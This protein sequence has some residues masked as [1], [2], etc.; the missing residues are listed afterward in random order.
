MVET[1]TESSPKSSRQLAMLLS[2]PPRKPTETPE[3]WAS[4]AME[5]L[6]QRAQPQDSMSRPPA[7][8]R[9]RVKSTFQKLPPEVRYKVGS[10]ELRE[11]DKKGRSDT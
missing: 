7:S 2:L 3:E 8:S 11:R 6:K 10:E 9:K 1:Q 5:D 4:R